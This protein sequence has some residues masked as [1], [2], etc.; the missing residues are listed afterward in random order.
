MLLQAEQLLQDLL[1]GHILPGNS[2]EVADYLR[3]RADRERIWGY[4][5]KAKE[6][7]NDSLAIYKDPKNAS[8]T[9]QMVNVLNNE[10][11]LYQDWSEIDQTKNGQSEAKYREAFE[12]SRKYYLQ[13]KS[14]LTPST[15][16]RQPSDEE[17]CAYFRTLSIASNLAWCYYRKPGKLADAKKLLEDISRDFF[18]PHIKPEAFE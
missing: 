14:G 10:G 12:E 4:Y 15:A 13:L 18:E 1:D 11:Q 2:P 6:L 3:C 16:T 5:K 7:Y 8:Y 17:Q 9:S